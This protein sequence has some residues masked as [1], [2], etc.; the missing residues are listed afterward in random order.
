MKKADVTNRFCIDFQ[1]LN[2]VTKFDTEPMPKL[3]KD[4][5]F[6]KVDYQKDFG[7]T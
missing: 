7:R 1:G 2:A 4:V 5:Y 6:S 3:G